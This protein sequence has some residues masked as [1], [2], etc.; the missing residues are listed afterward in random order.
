[1]G[2]IKVRNR[3]RI[4]T[5]MARMEL[6]RQAENEINRRI[7]NLAELVAEHDKLLDVI[8]DKRDN[9]DGK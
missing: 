1:M 2:Q 3:D 9:G 8:R 5:L 4:K 7:D 6:R